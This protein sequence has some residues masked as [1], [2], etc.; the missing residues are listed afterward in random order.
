MLLPL[1]ELKNHDF[2]LS[3][4][5]IFFQKPPYHQ[6]SPNSRKPNGF[7]YIV[8]GNCHYYHEKGDFPLSAGAMVYL[9]SGSHHTLIIESEEILFYRI[10]F[11]LEIGGEMVLFS[12]VPMKLCSHTPTACV[13]AILELAEGYQ[14]VQDSVAKT[15]LVCRML[16]S[17]STVVDTPRQNKLAPATAY[18]LE[19]LTEKVSCAF[20]AKLCCLSTAQ[21]YTL[22]HAEYGVP[23][24]EYRNDLLVRRATLLLKDGSYSV[25]EVAETLGFE[26]VSY[27]SRFFKKHTGH[28]PLDY[29]K[30]QKT[31]V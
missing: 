11:R 21:F 17:L 2:S 30:N 13:E 12:D 25:T 26:S 6:L 31:N 5:N 29:R 20:L 14:F 24:L 28:S 1:G 19:H 8:E 9:P 3:K 22:F 10:D 18:L 7:L 27:F 4:I 15:A 16:Q 23:P